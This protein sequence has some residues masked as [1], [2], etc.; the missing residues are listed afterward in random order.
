MVISNHLAHLREIATPLSGVRN[1]NLGFKNRKNVINYVRLS[2][3]PL[4][5]CYDEGYIN[6]PLTFS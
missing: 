6:K 1:D 4:V 3:L 5:A 2:A